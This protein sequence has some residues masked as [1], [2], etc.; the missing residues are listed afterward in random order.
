MIPPIR[1]NKQARAP[2]A[3]PKARCAKARARG[4]RESALRQSATATRS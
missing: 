2:L 3:R 4:G 1:D